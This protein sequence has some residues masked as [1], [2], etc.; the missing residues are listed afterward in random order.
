MH[1]LLRRMGIL[2]LVA[3]LFVTAAGEQEASAAL[4]SKLTGKKR[5][6]ARLSSNPALR[7]Q[8]LIVDPE[9]ILGGSVSTRYDPSLVRLVGY[10]APGNFAVTGGNIRVLPG[11]SLTDVII[12]VDDFLLANSA[13]GTAPAVYSELGFVQISFERR[14]SPSLTF[15]GNSV[16]P[17]QPG[18]RTIAEDGPTGINDTHALIFEYWSRTP[19]DARCEYEVYATPALSDVRSD[20]IVSEDDPANPIPYSELGPAVV[21]GSLTSRPL[22]P[23]PA[24]PLPPAAGVALAL[25]ATMATI[26]CYRRTPAN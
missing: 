13:A 26:R 22:E 23:T 16:I 11:T 17:N 24:V 6:T 14:P 4:A 2:S 3:A 1:S 10:L 25:L 8:Q 21:A 19:S 7:R 12:P 18:Y 15:G 20:F 9:G 5:F